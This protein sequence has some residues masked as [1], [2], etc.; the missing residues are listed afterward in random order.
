MRKGGTTGFV[1]DLFDDHLYG[2]ADCKIR[3]VAKLGVRNDAIGFQTHIHHYLTLRDRNDLAFNDLTGLDF[4]YGRG[5][6]LTKCLRLFFGG[7]STTLK[8][9]PVKTFKRL[10]FVILVH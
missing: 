9:I 6:L 8:R 4:F 5:I 3:I 7:G 2:I 1:F 10:Y